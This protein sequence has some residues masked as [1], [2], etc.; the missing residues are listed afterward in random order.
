LEGNFVHEFGPI[1]DLRPP[2]PVYPAWLQVSRK[3]TLLAQ[4]AAA[5]PVATHAAETA[6]DMVLKQAGCFPRDRVT[7][8]TIKE[9]VEGA[10]KWGR[11]APVAPSDDWF[12]EGLQQAAPPVDSDGDG[13]PDEWEDA[14]GF[15]KHDGR[16]GNRILASGYTAIE[17]YANARAKRLVEASGR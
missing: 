5:A 14:H 9:V 15:N 8:R 1:T 12:L 17:E 11:N 16:D 6:Y 3:G 4:P 7:A 2:G 13:M 10:G